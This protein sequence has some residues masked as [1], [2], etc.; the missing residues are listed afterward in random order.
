[1]IWKFNHVIGPI[2]CRLHEAPCRLAQ[3]L[4]RDIP[5]FALTRDAYAKNDVP[6]TDAR[7]GRAKASRNGVLERSGCAKA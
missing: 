4:H 2:K 5:W 7:F 1:M 6:L 3:D